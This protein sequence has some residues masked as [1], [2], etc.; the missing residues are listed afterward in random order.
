MIKAE[1]IADSKNPIGDRITTM[2]VRF[3]RIVL[4]EF[5]THRMFSRNSASS[6][7]I[8]F[9]KMLKM[10]SDDPFIPIAYQKE[11]KGMQGTE[12]ITDEQ[13]LDYLRQQHLFARNCAIDAAARVSSNDVTK[14]ICNRYLEPFMWHTAIVTA[15][16][17]E[18]FF[19]LRCPQY[20]V[21]GKTYRSKSDVYKDYDKN[22][23]SGI[24][25]RDDP[26]WFLLNAGQ[27][28]IHIM[29]LAEAM[30]DAYNESYPREL[31]KDEWHIPFGDKFNDEKIVNTL[32][33]LNGESF[34]VNG[35]HLLQAKIEIATARCARVSYMNY[36]G[37]DDYE[38]DFKLFKTLK[39]NGH[40][41]PLEHCAKAMD[42]D[43]H[44]DYMKMEGGTIEL[45][46]CR[47]FQ[48]FIQL[49]SLMGV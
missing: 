28:E 8:P 36:E 22:K 11:H 46:W 21:A 16:H 45:G 13:T 10:V 24:L 2:V 19:Q 23:G 27:A 39:E 6:R 14:Q 34:L 9:K 4:S 42:I 30:W 1:V 12:Y 43:D 15:T 48:G 26:N 44:D 18:N 38:S 40:A 33:R 25:D 17:W 5:N 20:T 3:P 32:Y 47:N 41:S 35:T 37:K 7:A 49:R 29:A 31:A